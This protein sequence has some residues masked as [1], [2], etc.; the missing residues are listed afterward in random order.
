MTVTA[1]RPPLL[2]QSHIYGI[3]RWSDSQLRQGRSGFNRTFME[4]KVNETAQY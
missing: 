4:L 1:R 3:E 2:F